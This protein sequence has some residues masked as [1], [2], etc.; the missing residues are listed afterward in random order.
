MVFQQGA[1]FEWMNVCNNVCFGPRITGVNP[2]QTRETVDHLLN[3]VGLQD[4]EEK[5]IYELYGG[6]QKRVALARGLTND[7]DVILMD[8]PLG[9]LD[10]LTREKMQSLVLKLWKETGKP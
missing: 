7:Q 6:M 4:F 3:I 5:A 1:L 8:E 2:S 9:A 10:A